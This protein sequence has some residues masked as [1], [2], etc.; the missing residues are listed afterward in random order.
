MSAT[1]PSSPT[2]PAEAS[3]PGHRACAGC[4][5]AAAVRI[6]METGRARLHRRQRHRLPG[7]L[8]HPASPRPPG[9]CLGFTPCSRTPPPSPPASRPR[10]S[11]Q[12]RL[13]DDPRPLPSAATAPPSTSASAALSGM[14]ERDHDVLYVCMDNEA[15]MNTGVQR[16]GSTPFAAS[17]TTSPAGRAVL[18][19]RSPEEGP[20]R[21]SSPLTAS[22]MSPSPPWR[23]SPTS[24]AR[25]R[26]ALEIRGAKYLQV[27]VPC[28]P[29]W[30]YDEQGQHRSRQ[31]R[32][33]VR[34][35]SRSSSGK[36]ARSCACARS[37]RSRSRS[38]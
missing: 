2:R 22:P 35:L 5:Q 18:R 17:T 12:G 30:G 9:A 31:A 25:S 16:S 23:S 27:H 6:V 32:R 28:P 19:R 26:S 10:C 4:G 24:S 21:P 38:T 20:A 1:E 11:R 3:F 14:F 29:G 8:Q 7:S 33:R 15:Y 36:S 34:P 13:D 37:S